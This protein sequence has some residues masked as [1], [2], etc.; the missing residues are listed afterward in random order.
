MVAT[1]ST[2]DAAAALPAWRLFK[3]LPLLLVVPFTSA[4]AADAHDWALSAPYVAKLASPL[5]LAPLA[6]R[7][8]REA[9]L[10]GAVLAAGFSLPSAMVLAEVHGGGQGTRGWRRAAYASDMALG[11]GLA[12]WGLWSI[13]KAKM[14]GHGKDG[15]D[16]AAEEEALEA[17]WLVAGTLPFLAMAQLGLI[18]FH[19]EGPPRLS[20]ALFPVGTG[21][22]LGLAAR[23]AAAL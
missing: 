4:R 2:P 16:K 5:L 8:P 18:P 22:G 1:R 12:G 23:L 10:P 21:G 11:L 7:E 6:A 13:R 17:A 15:D 20:L 19:A 3:L 14:R 9:L